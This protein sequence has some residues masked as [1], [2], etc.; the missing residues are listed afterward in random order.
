MID[1]VVLQIENFEVTNRKAFYPEYK[2][3]GSS[4]TKTKK[5]TQNKGFKSKTDT[6]VLA[7]CYPKLEIT[8]RVIRDTGQITEYLYV[9]ISLSK[10]MFGENVSETDPEDSMAVCTK[11]SRT[12]GIYGLYVAPEAIINSSLAQLHYAKNYLLRQKKTDCV[13]HAISKICPP[14]GHLQVAS[15]MYI[16]KNVLSCSFRNQQ[17]EIIFYNKSKEAS[18]VLNKRIGKGLTSSLEEGEHIKNVLNYIEDKEIL[19]VEYRMYKKSKVDKFF[20]DNGLDNT[21]EN[22]FDITVYK[23]C[24][25]NQ[26]LFLEGVDSHLSMNM[27]DFYNISML[28][29]ASS[30]K[31]LNDTILNT[32]YI[33]IML[34]DGEDHL[35]KLLQRHYSKKHGKDIVKRCKKLLYSMITEKYGMYDCLVDGV[36][37]Y[38]T[39]KIVISDN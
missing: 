32:G 17:H 23:E 3:V 22:A 34:K 26:I 8:Q 30:K 12:L 24:M 11:L 33:N 5:F 13:I 9:D 18:D 27:G 37:N 19:R 1:T 14:S 7:G 21:L 6:E 28:E 4:L 20:K 29:K 15:K 36:E 31:E 38:E 25:L 16:N 39:E 2:P 35:L 10:L